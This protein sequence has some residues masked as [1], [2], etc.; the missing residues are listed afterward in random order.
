MNILTH[1]HFAPVLI[2]FFLTF[3]FHE[4]IIV[5]YA[6]NAKTERYKQKG[7]NDNGKN[8]CRLFKS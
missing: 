1:T 3:S 4:C 7:K 2:C 5:V 6:N 8:E